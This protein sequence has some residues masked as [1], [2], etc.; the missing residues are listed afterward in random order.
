MLTRNLL[1]PPPSRLLARDDVIHALPDP[2]G[3]GADVAHAAL[4]QSPEPLLPLLEGAL[5]G[6][7]L[8]GALQDGLRLAR[9]G[10]QLLGGAVGALD[11]PVDDGLGPLSEVF[12]P[13]REG[14]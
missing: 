13:A 2:A 5:E 14:L 3:R 9:D 11:Q 12:A 8:V 10:R 6:E 7:G 4:E 1:L